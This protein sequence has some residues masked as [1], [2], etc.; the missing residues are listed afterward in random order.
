MKLLVKAIV[1]ISVSALATGC[2]VHPK[3][4]HKRVKP[5]VVKATIDLDAEHNDKTVIIVHAAPAKSKKCRKH[6]N[7][8]HCKR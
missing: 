2:V 7:H 3:A 8:W 5:V 1:L 6:G 4:P